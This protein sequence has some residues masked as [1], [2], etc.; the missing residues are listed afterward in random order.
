[1]KSYCALPY[2]SS[3]NISLAV[4]DALPPKKNCK[5]ENQQT[6]GSGK[7]GSGPLASSLRAVCPDISTTGKVRL[8]DCRGGLWAI[9]CRFFINLFFLASFLLFYSIF[10]FYLGSFT[11]AGVNPRPLAYNYDLLYFLSTHLSL[12]SPTKYSY[13]NLC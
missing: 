4:T 3:E 13:H 2:V 1:M 9:G 11:P 5:I 12:G 7:L 10:L 8:Q 6:S